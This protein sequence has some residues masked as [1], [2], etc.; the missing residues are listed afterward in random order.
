MRITLYLGIILSLLTCN[1]VY[2]GNPDSDDLN[3][4][5]GMDYSTMLL[6]QNPA[7][8]H[9]F[10]KTD[11][12]GNLKISNMIEAHYNRS[13][14][15][16][17]FLHYYGQ[18][19]D[20]Y[21]IKAAGE[22]LYKIGSI[23]GEAAY[24]RGQS[25]DMEYNYCINPELYYPYL[26][27]DTLGRGLYTFEKYTIKGGYGFRTGK[28][29]WG[30]EAKYEGVV[31]AK[32]TAP[33]ISNYD[34][35]IHFNFAYARTFGK[36]LYSFRVYPEFNKQSIRAGEYKKNAVKYFQ[37]YGFGNWNRKE[38]IAGYGMGKQISIRG[39]GAEF[40]VHAPGKLA[41]DNFTVLAG[42]RYHKMRTE[43]NNYKELFNKDSHDVY[44]AGIM[45]WQRKTLEC[46][47]VLE[48]QNQLNHGTENVYQNIEVSQE[49]N[50]YDY[51]KVGE[52]KLYSL[53]QSNNRVFAHLKF[54]VSPRAYVNLV[55][56]VSYTYYKE[57][58]KMPHNEIINSALTPELRI[59][60]GV[61]WKKNSIDGGI[62][63]A[64]KQ[65]LQNVFDV[66]FTDAYMFNDLVRI[67]FEIRGEK[68]WTG[69]AN[70]RYQRS[71]KKRNA[72]GCSLHWSYL[73][74]MDT[75][76]ACAQSFYSD[77]SVHNGEVKV[78]FLF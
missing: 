36:A 75:P 35:W 41:A 53:F 56:K 3:R 43:E 78:F 58:Y 63:A 61:K 13:I 20:N 25:R 45:N 76:D 11:N 60:G 54:H 18:N 34:S 40:S 62:Q 48:T 6:R 30:V 15:E 38:S 55:P 19:Q 27:G 69:E 44:A 70:L 5:E 14:N 66:A 12:K 72:I 32:K 74:R 52:N 28:N 10:N 22:H 50:L 59:G 1:Q 31:G 16:G 42:Y 68:S 26:V 73:Q 47:L 37:Y 33:K 51:F 23:Y 67:P 49:H 39:T 64:Y 46:E 65:P 77:R 21:G 2:A 29:F 9:W 8:R 17:D 4:Y 57:S 7:Y 71:L 24:S